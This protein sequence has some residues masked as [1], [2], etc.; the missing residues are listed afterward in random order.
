MSNNTSV[1]YLVLRVEC[2]YS[3]YL[4]HI[5]PVVVLYSGSHS[6]RVL[7]LAGSMVSGVNII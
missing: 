1:L 6:F 7:L 3:S 2:M 5:L 4:T